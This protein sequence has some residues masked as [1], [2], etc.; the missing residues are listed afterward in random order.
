MFPVNGDGFAIMLSGGVQLALIAENVGNVTHGVGEIQG[1][2]ESATKISG[3][4]VVG[5]R[6]IE[7]AKVSLDLPQ[8]QERARQ[9]SGIGAVPAQVDG[10]SK[11]LSR[12]GQAV[13]SAG[14]ITL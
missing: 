14:L 11:V 1:T 10:L 12:I 2:T 7:A 8:P 6:R 5:E 9:Y 3:F 13:L 4:S